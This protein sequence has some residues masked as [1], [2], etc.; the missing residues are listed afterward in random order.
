MN[1]PESMR[2]LYKDENFYSKMLTF[3]SCYCTE[4]GATN[5]CLYCGKYSRMAYFCEG[6]APCA[7]LFFEEHK[8]DIVEVI[9]S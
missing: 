6:D 5:L 3:L 9:T 8:G 7:S 2:E 4:T 1:F